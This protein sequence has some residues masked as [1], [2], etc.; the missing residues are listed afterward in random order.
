MLKYFLEILFL[1]E[2]FIQI[3]LELLLFQSL[4]QYHY[5]L[6]I[7]YVLQRKKYHLFYLVNWNEI[8]VV[9]RHKFVCR[10]ADSCGFP[11]NLYSTQIFLGW[12]GKG[13]CILLKQMN[14]W[15]ELPY[16]VWEKPASV[17]L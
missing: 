13:L 15:G 17:D 14:L 2:C 9:V 10:C 8:W 7:S 6:Q 4:K 5:S 1:H 11:D 3:L 16:S 12:F